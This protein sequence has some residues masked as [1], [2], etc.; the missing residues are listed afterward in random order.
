MITVSNYFKEIDKIGATS[1]PETLRKSHEFVVKGTNG[2]GSWDV[3]QTNETIRKVIDLY[4]S[5]LNEYVISQPAKKRQAEAAQPVQQ[6]KNE[7]QQHKP[8][9]KS[10]KS[11]ANPKV[12]NA[13]SPKT[14]GKLVELL[15]EEVKFIKRYVGLHNKIKSPG[16]ILNLIKALQRSIVQRLIRKE[17]LLAKEIQSIQDKLVSLYNSMKTEKL[18][19][20]NSKDLSRLVAIAGAEAVYPSINVIKRFVGMQGKELE[21]K[22]IEGFIRQIENAVKS[23]K[24]LREDPYADKVTRI[25]KLLKQRTSRTISVSKAELNGLEGI[26]KGCGCKP[27]LGKIYDT[28]GKALRRCKKRTYSDAKKGACSHNKGLTG[29]LTAEEIANREIVSLN[30]NY[31]WSALLGKPAKNFTMMIHGEPGGGKTTLLLKFAQYLAENFG[32]VIF[33][34]SEEFAATTLTS[35]VKELFNEFPPNLHFTE[36][37]KNYDLSDYDFIVLDSVNDL[38]LSVADFKQLKQ[39]Y[40]TAAFILLLQHTKAGQFKGGKEWEHEAEIAGE[41]INGVVTIYKNRY[42]VK[43]S[44]DFFNN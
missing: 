4:L 30:F 9:R 16:A 23:K 34:S 20:I 42:G 21:D 8:N 1:L 28:K 25:H 36:S 17:S 22:K 43:G 39:E 37:V 44:F 29:I 13:K 40:P 31:R 3:Y 15:R 12:S 27:D 41:I 26:L 24:I 35:K 11:I 10:L 14:S 33:I 6:I 7:K 18:I 2:G 5:K 19:E 32:K 38:G